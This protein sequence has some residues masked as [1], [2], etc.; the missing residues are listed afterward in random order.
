MGVDCFFGLEVQVEQ[1]LAYSE[2]IKESAQ[3]VAENADVPLE[4]ACQGPRL[5]GF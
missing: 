5:S 2:Q 3:W 4:R 1:L